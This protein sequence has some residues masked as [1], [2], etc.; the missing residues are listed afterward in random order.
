MTGPGSTRIPYITDRDD[1]PERHRH[2]YDAI[3]GSRGGVRGPFGVLMN[4]PEVAG[5]TGHLG[6]YIRYESVLPDVERELTI[7]NTAREW[8][9]AYEWAVHEPIARNVGVSP[10]AIEAVARRAS[11]DGLTET[12]RAIVL[13]GRELLRDNRATEATYESAKDHFGV[14]GVME[15]TATI[16]YYSMLACVLNA[17]EVTPGNDVA[18]LP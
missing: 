3:E 11:A 1:V 9:C 18:E 8:D 6:A 5:R 14:Q 2:H 17:F 13:Y 10:E 16:G 4:S 12:G 7:I 15:L